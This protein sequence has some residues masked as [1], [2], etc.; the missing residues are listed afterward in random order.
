MGA[1][2]CIQHLFSSQ[3]QRLR[4]LVKAQSR[5]RRVLEIILLVAEDLDGHCQKNAGRCTRQESELYTPK[6]VLF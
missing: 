1:G 2:P 3:A 5:R 4:D 6:V